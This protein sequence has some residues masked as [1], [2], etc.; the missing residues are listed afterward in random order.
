MI[1]ML[2][3]VIANKGAEGILLKVDGVGYDVLVH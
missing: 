2:E 3:G 1:G